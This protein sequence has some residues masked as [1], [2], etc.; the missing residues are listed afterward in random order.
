VTDVAAHP[1]KHPER[2][3]RFAEDNAYQY[4]KTDLA[5]GSHEAFWQSGETTVREDLVP[6]L[7]EFQL[8]R[9][10]GLE[11]G[12]GVGRLVLPLSQV[13]RR[14]IG[15]DISKGMIRRAQESARQRQITNAQFVA[16]S[17]PGGLLAVLPQE[18]GRVSFVY[19]L[20]VFQHI[21]DFQTIESYI[22]VI[23]QMLSQDGAAYLQ[24]D[25]RVQTLPYYLKTALPDFVLPKYVRRG[26]RRIRRNPSEIE[27]TFV[28]HGLKVIQEKTPRSTDHRYLLRLS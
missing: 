15:I 5:D 28:R 17:E 16:I 8:S 18:V 14:M 4:I 3:E 20:L 27:K 23:G 25:T 22:A 21:P 1:R 9:D 24:F 10:C 11:I 26:I 19:S 13:F 2:W 6:L 7:E 12:C